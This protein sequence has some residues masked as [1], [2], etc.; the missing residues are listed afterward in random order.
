VADFYQVLS[1]SPATAERGDPY[2]VVPVL[3]PYSGSWFE[4]RVMLAN[5]IWLPIDER[6][7]DFVREAYL[8]MK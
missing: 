2:L 6:G 5:S 7:A 1:T 8:S 4:Q 3:V